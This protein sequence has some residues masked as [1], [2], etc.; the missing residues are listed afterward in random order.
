MSKRPLS[1]TSLHLGSQ[2]LG[3]FS[4]YVETTIVGSKSPSVV[5]PK[6]TSLPSNVPTA[7][8]EGFASG[9]SYDRLASMFV[10]AYPLQSSPS[11]GSAIEDWPVETV[12]DLPYWRAVLAKI[13][14]SERDALSRGI[15]NHA[16]K[17]TVSVK[18]GTAKAATLPEVFNI[19]RYEVQTAE[20]V[21]SPARPLNIVK[22]KKN[23]KTEKTESC[24]LPS[25]L[26]RASSS[27]YSL[28]S[29]AAYVALPST[30]KPTKQAKEVNR[31]A[32]VQL[33]QG[34]ICIC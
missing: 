1:R 5:A 32:R 17:A 9:K 27:S 11:F 6:P 34:R 16:E 10:S 33:E 19:S 23:V 3:D 22:Q 31:Q 30:T 21:L 25:F 26:T 24:T 28:S 4:D 14:H 8:C 18:R 29:L 20:I 12:A 15:L 2:Y 13:P 7:A